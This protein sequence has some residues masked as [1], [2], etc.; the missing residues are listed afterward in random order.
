MSALPG[1]PPPGTHLQWPAQGQQVERLRSA[2]LQA[3]EAGDRA[4]LRAAKQQVLAA[5]FAPAH[6]GGPPAPALRLALRH[7]AWQMAGLL[8]PREGRSRRG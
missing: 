7:L 4:A 2:L 8:L 6:G 3:L 5:A 1:G